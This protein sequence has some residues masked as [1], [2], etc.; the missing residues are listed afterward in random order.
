M[1]TVVKDT[2]LFVFGI[3]GIIWQT[4]TGDVNYALLGVFTAMVGVP[5]FTNMVTLI[6]GSGTTSSQPT[7]APSGSSSE[8]T[9][10]SGGNV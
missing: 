5:G 6:R 10:S 4:V 1:S 7:S 2:I 8:S 9:N 3:G